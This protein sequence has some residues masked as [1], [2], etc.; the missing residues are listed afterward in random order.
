MYIHVQVLL[1]LLWSAL[2]QLTHWVARHPRAG[3]ITDICDSLHR[4]PL[5]VPTN[6]Q[7]KAACAISTV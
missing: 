4:L 2:Q 5:M 3:A 6:P 1:S 7:P